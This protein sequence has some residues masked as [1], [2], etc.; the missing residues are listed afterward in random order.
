MP[1][2]AATWADFVAGWPIF[3]DAVVCGIVAGAALGF[4][5][6]W[7]VVRR[8]VFV[9]AVL[10]Q[11]AGLGVA[12]AFWVG[13]ALDL[14]AEPLVGAVLLSLAATGLFTLR[15][16]RLH[17]SRESVLAAAWVLAGGLAV[18]IGERITAEAHDIN[19]ILFGS[20]VLVRPVDLALVAGV[21]AVVVGGALLARR[22]LLFAAF[23][24]DVAR[25]HGLP[26]SILD[27]A[28]WLGVALLVSV[29][30]RAL[31]ALPVFAF[32]VLPALA[33]L[34]LVPWRWVF[35]VAALLGGAAGG[36]GYLLAFFENFPVG[37]SQT[38]V[39]GAFVLV[40][41][42]LGWLRRSA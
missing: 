10:S 6:V 12:L 37:A 4:L 3:R 26:V 15:P 20:A 24:P 18:M 25:V 7:V 2:T 29:A 9:A 38:A 32:S 31:G 1:E 27:G 5:G 30:T 34:L 11:A 22:G 8:M 35:P 16:E 42:P 39:A 33:A 28:L 40:A 13:M 36:V 14:P 21:A 19:A 23:D 17:L 41:V